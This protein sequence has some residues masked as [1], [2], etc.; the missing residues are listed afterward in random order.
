MNRIPWPLKD[1][2]SIGYFKCIEGYSKAG[3]EVTVAALN[4][5]KHFFDVNKIPEE[6]KKL[7]DWNAS[8]IDNRVKI[9]GA[10]LNLFTNKSYNISRFISTDFELLLTDLLR[11]KSFDVIVFE[12]L[13]MMPYFDIVSRNSSALTV[14]RQYNIEHEIWK[15]LA[16]NER[17]PFKKGYLNLLTNR[18]ENFEKENINTCDMLTVLTQ[19]DKDD[20]IK[21]GATKPIHIAPIGIE[22]SKFKFDSV[23]EKKISLFHLGSMEWLP[24]QEAIKWFIENVWNRISAK[25]P[26][27]KFY[28]AGRGMPDS[29]KQ[30]KI[31]NLI[32]EGEVEDANKF[33]EGKQI[34]IV[35][36]FSGSGLRVKILE[37]M[38]AGKTI[39][40]TKLGAQGIEYENCKHLMI[41]DT[42]GEFINAIEELVTNP[43]YAFELGRNAKTLIEEKYDNTKIIEQLLYVYEGQIRE[44][45]NNK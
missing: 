37:G 5:Q 25:F 27:L 42:A 15:T 13:F 29:F 39:V 10:F 28:I 44:K 8:Y 4:T 24:N 3:C 43:G 45:D 40:S 34:M 32:V 11:K 2:G 26:D 31:K 41:A 1:G 16:Q 23:S 17:N 30:L 35:P 6:V 33:M 38:A 12:S 21:M 20:L 36:L 14:L 18:L 7:A 22:L 9:A 19:N